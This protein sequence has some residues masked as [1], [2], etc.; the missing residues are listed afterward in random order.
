MTTSIRLRMLLYC[1]SHSAIHSHIILANP[2]RFVKRKQEVSPPVLYSPR[3]AGKA[4]RR[5]C[6]DDAYAYVKHKIP[7]LYASPICSL[8]IHTKPIFFLC[9]FWT[10]LPFVGSYS[11]SK[12]ETPHRKAYNPVGFAAVRSVETLEKNCF[13]TKTPKALCEIC[14]CTPNTK[15]RRKPIFANH[16]H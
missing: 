8:F 11:H 9:L 5:Q 15:C 7:P 13:W 14:V 1:Q 10:E 2:I 3:Q 4:E 16:N 6:K 12:C